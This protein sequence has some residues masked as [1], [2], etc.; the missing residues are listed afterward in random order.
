[1][2]WEDVSIP[3]VRGLINDYSLPPD[4][5][6]TFSDERLYDLL[7]V[8]AYFVVSDVSFSTTYVVNI[9]NKT[10][11]PDP[12]ANGDVDFINFMTLRAA[13]I[14]DQGQVRTK[15]LVSNIS[16]TLGPM[17]LQTNGHLQGFLK[18]LEQGPCKAYEELKKD[19]SFGNTQVYKAIVNMMSHNNF[20][21]SNINSVGDRGLIR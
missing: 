2:A 15:A 19:Y 3:I 21:P 11:I 6:P 7:V 9:N 20:N 18:I 17:N 4:Y 12:D 16:A 13:C 14:A 1:M 10:I 5:S 8:A